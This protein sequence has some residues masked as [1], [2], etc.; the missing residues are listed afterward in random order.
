MTSN[1]RSHSGET[2]QSSHPADRFRPT[3]VT[4]S[5]TGSAADRYAV[6]KAI[7]E[8]L[9]T[10][11]GPNGLD[12]M[13]IDR[14]GTVIVTNTGATV[15]DGLEIDAPTGQVV[16]SAIDTQAS[17]IGDGSTTMA[18]LVG[19]LLTTARDLIESGLHPASVIKGY[20]AAAQLANQYVTT[21][22]TPVSQSDT[23]RLTNVA[24]TAITGRWDDTAAVNLASIAVEALKRLEFDPAGLTLHAYPGGGVTDAEHIDGILIDTDTSSTDSESQEVHSQ[25]EQS[26]TVTAPN[27]ALVDGEITQAAL[28]KPATVSVSDPDT[29]TEI[30]S[31]EQQS[32]DSR[33]ESITAADV[34][35]VVCQQAIDDELRTALDHHG[36][37]SLARTRRDEFDA[38]AQATGAD[39]VAD[40]TELHAGRVGTADTV[41]HR[42][43][44]STPVVEF[45]GLPEE[46]HA[47]VVIR[48]GTDHVAEETRRI[49]GD[50][51][52]NLRQ[53]VH[54]DGVVPGGGATW[55]AAACHVAEHAQSMSDRSQIACEAFADSLK[56][57][58]RTLAHNAGAD[59]LT[60]M[61]ALAARHDAG[62]TDAGVSATGAVKRMVKSNVVEPAAVISGCLS[63]AVETTTM[64][65]RI[66]DVLDAEKLDSTVGVNNAHTDDHD[67]H[68]HASDGEHGGYP[69]A[70]S[71]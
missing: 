50:C 8:T 29:L 16:R 57:I 65:V 58:P 62:D 67:G 1:S 32:R 71:H 31:H 39:S 7:A 55:M 64:V 70:L 40:V 27:I 36:V 3:P 26:Q 24:V 6:A 35:V 47:S 4:D 22:S 59:P 38:I 53:T 23:D 46:H 11:L 2:G 12:K 48:G 37:V 42:T 61:S 63:T 52:Q 5:D 14:S 28:S 9:S 30:R 34:D 66:D 10:T 43:I 33:L 68:S 51:I 19:E 41:R 17:R 15:L 56:I 54:G 45:T 44:G 13:L 21:A 69:W 60:I 18:L 25:G 49:V 20:L